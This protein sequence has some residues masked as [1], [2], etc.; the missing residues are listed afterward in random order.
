LLWSNYILVEDSINLHILIL[1]FAVPGSTGGTLMFE[2]AF[3]GQPAGSHVIRMD[4]QPN[5]V[6]PFCLE[7]VSDQET[8]R[9]TCDPFAA[10]LDC[11]K[12][13]GE[14]VLIQ[15]IDSLEEF[16]MPYDLLLWGNHDE[17]PLVFAPKTCLLELLAKVG[18]GENTAW[19]VI[20]PIVDIKMIGV[21]P[22]EIHFLHRAESNGLASEHDILLSPDT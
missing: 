14:L 13:I 11:I 20:T 21:E 18:L 16:D 4:D 3:L 10:L 22:V 5:P 9:F 2:A 19:K 1:A 6:H 17:H 12:L 15:I 7:Q 8:D